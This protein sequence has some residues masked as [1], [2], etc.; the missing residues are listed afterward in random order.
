M[1]V[2]H[3]MPI[4]L[5]LSGRQVE[6]EALV[7]RGATSTV[8]RCRG[9]SAGRQED[10]VFALKVGRTPATRVILAEEA[11]RLLWGNSP[12]LPRLFSAGVLA[13]SV[14]G[15]EIPQDAPFLLLE[16]VSGTT[17]RSFLSSG[18]DLS[19]KDWFRVA[20]DLAVAISNLHA[21]GIA[22]G[23]IKP[24]NVMLAERDGRWRAVLLDMG[25]SVAADV[26]VL[27]GGTPRYLA[28]ECFKGDPL[29][30]GRTRDLWALGIVLAECTDRRC[31]TLD[32]RAISEMV[33]S[34]S[35]LGEIIRPLLSDSPGARPPASWVEMQMDARLG[36]KISGSDL[37]QRRHALIK[38]AYLNVRRLE[39]ITAARARRISL[40]VDGIA[41]D[42]IEQCLELLQG[43]ERIRGSQRKDE[44]L[45]IADLS[46]LGRLRFL[47]ELVGSVA[48]SWP[49]DPS[50]SDGALLKRMLDVASDC[51][52]QAL[53]LG[54][55]RGT[56]RSELPIA[57]KSPVELALQLVD[58][59]PRRDVLDAAE[60]YASQN[61][62][63]IAFRLA[64]GRRLRLIGENGRALAVF[65]ADATP[66]CQAE[67]A[68][69]ARR[70]AD[71]DGALTRVGS[72]RDCTDVGVLARVAAT[73]GRILL[74]RGHAAQALEKT[75][76]A[77]E[78]PPV[79][80]VRALAEMQLGRH[81]A[82]LET[83]QRAQALATSDEEQARLSSL[84]GMV[85]HA[86][87]H[88]SAASSAFRRAVEYAS[89]AGA[90]LEE[91]TYLTGLAAAS[92]D[93][94]SLDEAVVSAERASALFEALGQPQRAARAALN[95][96]AAFV[97]AGA[98]LQAKAAAETA[99]ALARNARDDRCAAYV[100]LALVDASNGGPDAAEH[101]RRAET[102]LSTP[103][104][105]ERLL[106]AARNHELGIAVDVEVCDALAR[107]MEAGCNAVFDWW[108][109]RARRMVRDRSSNTAE[110][111]VAELL[112][113]LAV[114][115]SAVIRG[116]AFAAGAELSSLARLGDAARRL[117]SAA[118]EDV[119]QL[120]SGCSAEFR[121]SVLS[122]DWVKALRPPTAPTLL[123][124]Q[125]A[126]IENLVRA[127]GR[128]EQLRPLLVQVLDAL[129]LW[130]GVERGL[131]LLMA[132]GGRLIPRVGRNLTRSDLVGEQL[133]L[134]HT[135]AARALEQAEP[136]VAVDASG[137]LDSVHAS[138]HALKLRS[139]LCVPLMARGEAMGVVYLDDRIRRGAF[140]EKEL[141]WVRLVSA[142]AAVAIADARDRLLLRRAARRAE[143]AEKR[144]D[145]TLSMRE[146]ELGEVRVELARSNDHVATRHRYDEIIGTSCA[147]QS[148]L[149]LVDRVVVSDVPLLLLGESGTGKEMIARAIHRNGP[150]NAMAFVAENCGAIPE[151]L[152][153][154]ALFGHVRGAFTGAS[155]SR[156]G[157]FDVADQGTLFLDEIAE[158]SLAMQ[159]KLLRVLEEGEFWPVGSERSRRV[160]VRIMAATHR[161]LDAMVA[162]GTFR[163]DLF[164]RLNVVSVRIPALRE[165]FGDVPLLARHFVTRYA[166]GKPVVLDEEALELLSRFPW[167]GNVRQLENEMRR[168]LVLCEGVITAAHLS[169]EVR[170]VALQ[171]R[172]RPEGLDLRAHL[173]SL[174]RDLVTRAL[175]RTHG[176]QTR[177]AELLGV[178]RFGLQKMVR[179]LEIRTA[180][181]IPAQAGGSSKSS[182]PSGLKAR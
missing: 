54:M 139:V 162:A 135:L 46:S 158:M 5:T 106:L 163:Q 86:T 79:L 80:E 119:Q 174:E 32:S 27:R 60:A 107:R 120:V 172:P 169:D 53:T 109:A 93:A 104:D 151:T 126:D 105:E 82:A 118:L 179:R 68:E 180:E 70:A 115:A 96:L 66:A 161:D 45:E 4:Q 95:R 146:A 99:L 31:M 149:A 74:D 11:E 3:S 117:H 21:A 13:G 65:D 33:R 30:D 36:T 15:D 98:T 39:L 41:R 164:Y 173:D 14:L 9:Q 55:L 171:A 131:L 84:V 34:W 25:L 97:A 2:D 49:I 124:E 144:M 23:D 100:H 166:E 90:L 77:P 167:P 57:T 160:D 56:G 130:T 1:R 12:T 16:W 85:Q 20:G 101:V 122:R 157:L 152:L 42:W 110:T 145:L 83:L 52:P 138:V 59:P 51:E 22:H 153:E 159:T 112:R 71:S 29:S 48:A 63:P 75:T 114:K 62:V 165:R 170:R 69:T 17:L 137:E 92:V 19:E 181:A 143:R 141:A 73:E 178:S 108:G 89:R 61:A 182:R 44:N 72:L 10:C 176:N 133:E 81:A 38:R 125:V 175:E 64:L 78:S 129:V 43:I 7:G 6:L 134:S 91:A 136:I 116:P 94:G 128:F 35:G 121:L 154:S 150:R 103:S 147:M 67:A 140:G 156:A 155:R 37:V 102:L 148:L 168:A 127:L 47:V 123:P 88:A 24:E 40:R 113:L 26:N 142:V 18:A 177:A 50:D 28:P 111:V 132:P 8:W 87:G 76:H 58:G